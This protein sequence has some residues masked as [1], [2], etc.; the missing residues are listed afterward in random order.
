MSFSFYRKA[1]SCN[2]KAKIFLHVP[3]EAKLQNC[4]SI[5]L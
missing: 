4:C 3:D 2:F 1:N 5:I